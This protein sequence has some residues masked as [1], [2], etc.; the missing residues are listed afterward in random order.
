[1]FNQSIVKDILLS[2]TRLYQQLILVEQRYRTELY[3][4]SS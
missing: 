2:L 1:M 4:G 3:Q